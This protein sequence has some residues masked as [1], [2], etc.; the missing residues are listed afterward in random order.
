MA[1]PWRSKVMCGIP[2]ITK[3][4]KTEEKR[5]RKEEKITNYAGIKP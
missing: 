2:T 3:S 1:Q 5:K 4:N